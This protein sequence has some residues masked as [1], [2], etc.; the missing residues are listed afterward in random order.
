MLCKPTFTVFIP[1]FFPITHRSKV[2]IIP[3]LQINRAEEEYMT[4]PT[5]H[6]KLEKDKG[7]CFSESSPTF[8]VS[9]PFDNRR[10]EVISHCSFD[11]HFPNN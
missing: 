7:S 10:C 11:L 8:V 6:S 3:L 9:C 2:V 5:S 4:C 1:F